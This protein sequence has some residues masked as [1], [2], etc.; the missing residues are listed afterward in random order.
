[1][2]GDW[3]LRPA[4]W[5]GWIVAAW[6]LGFAAV[7]AGSPE[8][9]DPYW[10]IRA[11][12]ENLDG[13]PWAR[14]DSWSWAPVDGLFYPN[15]PG[16]NVLLGLSWR[17]GGYWGVFLLSFALLATF[18][19][20]THLVARRLG[21]RPLPALAGVVVTIVLAFPMLNA[22]ATIAVQLLLLIGL[23][24]PDLWRGRANRFGIA[25]NAAAAALGG[26]ALSIAGNWTHLSWI[27]LAPLM[28]VA[29]AVYWLSQRL[30][31]EAVTGGRLIALIV[32]GTAGLLIGPLASPYGLVAGMERTLET[33]RVAQGLMVE[34]VSPFTPGMSPQWLVSALAA[35]ILTALV[36]GWLVRG[37][38]R[39]RPRREHALVAALASVGVPF[40][41]A[42]LVGVRFL[43]L[44]LLTLA[45][46]TAW[47]ATRLAD[48]AQRAANR[49][50]NSS[51]RG[52]IARRWT[53]GHAWRVVLTS[54]AVL[55]LPG[56]LLLGPVAHARPAE[57]EA[58]AALPSSCRLYSTMG[59]SAIAILTR[60]DVP[61]W[62]DSR[63]DYY[64]RE[65]LKEAIVYATGQAPSATPPGATCVVLPDPQTRSASPAATTRLQTEPGWDYRGRVNGFDV[66]VR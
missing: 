66:W 38:R 22:R 7:R 19:G 26:A 51:S 10:Q 1:M 65:R 42:G 52:A 28:A 12:L 20:L 57:A 21:A 43:G 50:S 15:S 16:W 47:G 64:G 58:L 9:R 48:A 44:A 31:P 60:P 34:W 33:Q 3:R 24:A 23:V 39:G 63:V 36:V 37:L 62:F 18:L 56:V 13:V 25:G 27:T 30:A 49:T 40:A 17:A 11:G 35:A 5:N 54:V 4:I 45:P 61:V 59:V 41:L 55:L 8:E 46:V 2:R 6:L 29:W 53:G 32:G 14:P